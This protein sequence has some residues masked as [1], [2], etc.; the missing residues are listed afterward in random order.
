MLDAVALEIAA[1]QEVPELIAACQWLTLAGWLRQDELWQRRGV[2]AG[3]W[4]V[5]AMMTMLGG[6][7][8]PFFTLRGLGHT[9]PTPVLP[10]VTG[11]GQRAN[12]AW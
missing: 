5:A 9:S 4:L 2:F 3:L 11:L 8:I 10:Y 1:S 7:V 6:R 12:N